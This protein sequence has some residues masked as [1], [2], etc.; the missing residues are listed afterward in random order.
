MTKTTDINVISNNVKGIQNSLKRL[1]S[2]LKENMFYNGVLFFQ[3]TH[4][5]SE[6]EIQWKDEFK[7][8][9]SF[10]HGKTNSCGVA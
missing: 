6:D 9:L 1:S 7:G 5:S 3:E 2:F 8:A 4:S 10:S